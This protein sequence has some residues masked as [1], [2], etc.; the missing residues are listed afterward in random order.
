MVTNYN[1]FTFQLATLSEVTI[2]SGVFGAL[3]RVNDTIKYG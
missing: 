1:S 2:I 3:E